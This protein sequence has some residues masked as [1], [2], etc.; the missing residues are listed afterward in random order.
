MNPQNAA[1]YGQGFGGR[2][3]HTGGAAP[4]RSMYQQQSSLMMSS[5]ETG[6]AYK[7]RFNS[8]FGDDDNSAGHVE[9]ESGLSKADMLKQAKDKKKVAK[10]ASKLK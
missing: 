2:S 6:A 8:L 5:K 7:K 4:A 10:A 9:D 1:P 3:L